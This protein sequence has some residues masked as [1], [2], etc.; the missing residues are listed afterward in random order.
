MKNLSLRN[1]L[2]L[3]FLAVGVI[4]FAIIGGVS[5]MKSGSALSQKA[6]E[7]L[8]SS[9]ETKKT[10]IERFFNERRGDMK[11]MIES[12]SK[13]QE[14]AVNKISSIQELKKS[15][16]TQFF[17]KVRNDISL[18]SESEDVKAAYKRLK[19][20]HDD[21][22]FGEGDAYDVETERYKRIWSEFENSL[23]NYVKKFGYYDVFVICRPHG[24]VMYSYEKEKDLGANLSM[25]KYRDEALAD[26]WKR[27]VSEK[28]IVFEDYSEYAPSNGAQAMFTGAPVF[29]SSG[30]VTAVVALQISSERI[31]SIVQQR[32][33]L[34]EN[35]E[36]YLAAE[37][38]DRVEFRSDLTTMGDGKYNTGYDITD[39]VPGY[40]KETLSGKVVLDTFTDSNGN[41]VIAGGDLVK[42]SDNISWAMVT[43]ENLEDALTG[44][45]K[46]EKDYFAKY[47]D[48]YG[49]YDLFL[50]NEN[51]YVYYTVSKEADYQTNLVD[52]E[53]S[54]SNLGEITRSVIS[55]KN[56]RIADFKPYEPSGG[57]PAAFIAGPLMHNNEVETVVAMQLSLK[58][59]NTIM[60]ERTGMGETGETYLVGPDKRMRSDSFLDPENHSVD[61]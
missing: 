27:A 55:D 45:Q 25:G 9:R 61:A 40:L 59:I 14:E 28:K 57:E 8:E 26:I 60:Q 34:S 50:I 35:G 1:K 31:N 38:N 52:G 24:H 16:I 13:I 2:I 15:Q 7:Q 6:F 32:K 4:P 39:I 54:G 56:I 47:I 3:S 5:L 30:N 36:T 23:G 58:A 22:G 53:F 17:E 43:K 29:D 12:V 10:Q 37:E 44:G 33:G 51:G 49:Y 21:M 20:Y 42:I 19:Q 11:V 18:L 41:P 46:G 48:A